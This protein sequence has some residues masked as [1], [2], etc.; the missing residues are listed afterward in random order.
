[1]VRLAWTRRDK[2]VIQDCMLMIETTYV[3]QVKLT[4]STDFQNNIERENIQIYSITLEK[5]FL[6]YS[7]HKTQNN[8]L[9]SIITIIIATI[10][11][12]QI[13]KSTAK[14]PIR[15]YFLLLCKLDPFISTPPQIVQIV[16]C[17]FN[18]HTYLLN[19]IKLPEK[20]PHINSGENYSKSLLTL[21]STLESSGILKVDLKIVNISSYKILR[22]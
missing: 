14:L 3:A 5:V 7:N 22:N 4:R 6:I 18:G 8:R 2:C 20:V 9:D 15:S 16:C 10:N 21:N 13:S 17:L 1:M 19:L 11:I 12:M